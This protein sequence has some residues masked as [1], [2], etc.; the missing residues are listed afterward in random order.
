[1]NRIRL[2]IGFNTDTTTAVVGRYGGTIASTQLI[3]TFNGTDSLD[4]I[5]IGDSNAGNSSVGSYGYTVALQKA[6]KNN[7][8]IPVYATPLLGNG[9]FY[10]GQTTGL[11]QADNMCSWGVGMHSPFN[12]QTDNGQVYNLVKAATANYTDAVE[13]KTNLN[14]NSTNYTVS[15]ST[16]MLPKPNGF[17][18]GGEYVRGDETYTSGASENYI[19]VDSKAPFNNTNDI[20]YASGPS[21]SYRLVCGVFS[22]VSGFTAGQFKLRIR[23]SDGTNIA[24]SPNYISTFYPLAAITPYKT[25]TLD[26]NAPVFSTSVTNYRASWDGQNSGNPATGPFASLWSSII[27]LNQ[28]GCSVSN[29][30]YHG[31]LTTT[32]IADRVEGMNLL[33]EC[34]L[35]EILERQKTAGGTGNALIFINSG[36]NQDTT[37]ANYTSSCDRIIAAITTKWIFVGGQTNKLSFVFSLTHPTTSTGNSSTW[38]TNRSSYLTAAT[39][40]INFQTQ[41]VNFIDIEALIPSW[42]LLKNK[43]YATNST[44]EAHLSLSTSTETSTSGYDVVTGLMLNALLR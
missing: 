44:N 26:F 27:K 21:S 38:A 15:D 9:S 35:K 23:G 1:M 7:Y 41:N 28:K 6:L 29:L 36:I 33:L 4:I 5:T 17:Q 3:N 37:T 42:E 18:W 19:I 40:W 12:G 31:G 22:G 30:I 16:T 32:Q 10:V 25:A 39:A 43:Y 34:Y 14:F 13:L 8:K 24:I 11:S 2:N 20:S